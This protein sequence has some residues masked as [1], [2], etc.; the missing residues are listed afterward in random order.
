MKLNVFSIPIYICNIDLNKIKLK[1]FKVK[2]QWLS[3]TESSHDC[4]NEITEDSTKYILETIIKLINQDIHKAYNITL[5]SIWQNNYKNNYY[6][7]KHSHPGSHFSF[8][9]YKKIKE[10]NTV[11]FNPASQLIQSYYRKTFLSDLSLF[12]DIFKVECREGQIIVFP[13][14]LEHMVLKNSNSITISGNTLIKEK[15]N[16]EL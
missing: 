4:H 14:Y 9:I 5:T 11:F 13:S 6:Q 12:S 16:N 15:I 10:S 8:V 1:N 7:E 3:Q 2:R